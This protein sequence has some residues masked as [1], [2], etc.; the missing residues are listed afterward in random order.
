MEAQRAIRENNKYKGGQTK[1][2]E[3]QKQKKRPTKQELT[4]KENAMPVVQKDTK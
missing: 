4:M 3:K 1:T 2:Q